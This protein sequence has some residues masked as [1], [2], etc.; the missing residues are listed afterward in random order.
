[1]TMPTE[2]KVEFHY[3]QIKGLNLSRRD[4]RILFQWES[5]SEIA[6]LGLNGWRSQH[7]FDEEAFY[8]TPVYGDYDFV[9]EDLREK[10]LTEKK[11]F[12]IPNQNIGKEITIEID[13]TR[14]I[15]LFVSRKSIPPFKYLDFLT[16]EGSSQ[17]FIAGL[18]RGALGLKVNAD[19]VQY[20]IDR[21]RVPDAGVQ[22]RGV[23]L[24][25]RV[26][27]DD[28]KCPLCRE[29]YEATETGTSSELCPICMQ[30]NREMTRLSGC[31]HEVCTQCEGQ[32]KIR[33]IRTVVD[34]FSAKGL[35]A[36]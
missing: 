12:V 11:R 16:D 1:M 20:N 27:R 15:K 30:S 31:T 9:D 8:I 22:F 4:M 32:M 29:V 17:T 21:L 13:E 2:V 26:E 33:S 24:A 34:S 3:Q 25:L 6:D 35:E 19:R 10:P 5:D 36:M 28:T 14:V 7:S 23:E 18:T